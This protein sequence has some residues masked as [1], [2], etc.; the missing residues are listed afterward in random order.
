MT[1]VK[2]LYC[3]E[4]V[5]K[6]RFDVL[7]V[8]RRYAHQSCIQKDK[9]NQET[10]EKIH[11]K[12]RT[13]LGA[14]YTKTKIDNQ[15]KNLIEGG[16]SPDGILKTLEYWYDIKGNDPKAANGGIGIVDY[17][18]NEAQDYFKRKEENEL[19]YKDVDIKSFMPT[20]EIVYQTHP[21]PFKKPK[22]VKLFDLK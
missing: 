21:S 6:E 12:M 1:Q 8:G 2:C 15:L 16:R 7:Q 18:Y 5:S 9:V 13:V 3:G 10:K 17:V 4:Y 22:R 11:Q 19:R 14:A 20:E